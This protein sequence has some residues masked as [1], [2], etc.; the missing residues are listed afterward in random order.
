MIGQL[1]PDLLEKFDGTVKEV[2]DRF[3]YL[4]SKYEELL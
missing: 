1:E 2:Y 3:K 4:V